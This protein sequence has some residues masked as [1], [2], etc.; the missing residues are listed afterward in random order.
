MMLKI[1]TTRF[2]EIDIHA[3]NIIRM[4]QGM[5]GLPQKRQFV[6][7]QHKTNS[8]FCWYQSTE[9]PNLAFV[10]TD[11]LLF[12]PDYKVDLATIVK[13]LAWNGNG[14]TSHLMLYVVVN[15]PQGS[16]DKMTANLIGPLLINNK[17]RQ[18]VQAVI[19][20]SPYSHKAP[21]MP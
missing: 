11:P 14:E 9:D 6:I 8:P 20:D 15:I 2:G 10:I 19:P 7:L 21:L 12:L 1:N 13:D 18:A 4:P 3:D 16:P 5:I 17:T